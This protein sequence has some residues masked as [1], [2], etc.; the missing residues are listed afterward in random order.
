MTKSALLEELLG[1]LLDALQLDACAVVDRDGLIIAS[2][3]AEGMNDDQVG[4]VT[5]MADKMVGRIKAEFGGQKSFFTITAVGE[6]KY[7][8]ASAG[9]EAILTL[10]SDQEIDDNKLRLYARHGAEKAAHLVRGE[11]TI[12]VD[13]P[14]IL[15]VIASFGG[16]LPKGTF[17]TKVVVCGDYKVGKTSLIRRFVE[18]K[19]QDDYLSTIGVDITKKSLQIAEDLAVNF[20]LW[21]IAGQSSTQMLPYRKRFYSGANCA[22][23]VY[24]KTRPETLENTKKWL[25]DI[26]SSVGRV[27]PIVL[28]GNKNDLVYDEKVSTAVAKQ[29]A[30]DLGFHFIE[31]SAKTG[32]NVTDAFRYLA[33]KIVRA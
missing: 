10:V 11:K 4:A 2:V 12:S 30:E 1:N 28:V 5:A 14:Q 7:A 33:Y 8:F 23:L 15:E 18:D 26:Q 16:T 24:D 27:I 31:T 21:D 25:K 3:T 9:P 17:S 19:F 29:F 20:L 6:K 22:L 13:L 32:E